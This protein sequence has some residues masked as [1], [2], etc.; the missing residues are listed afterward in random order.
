MKEGYSPN[1]GRI[2]LSASKVLV[3]PSTSLITLRCNREAITKN[4]AQTDEGKVE[5]YSDSQLDPGQQHL[6]LAAH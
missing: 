1:I 6:C 5:C 3:T 4:L 2:K